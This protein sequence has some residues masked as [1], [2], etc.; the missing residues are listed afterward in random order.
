MLKTIWYCFFVQ[1]NLLTGLVNLMVDTLFASAVKALFIL[2][3]YT[4][5]LTFIVGFLDFC[6]IWLK[7]GRSKFEILES[8]MPAANWFTLNPY[9]TKV[10]ISTSKW[11]NFRRGFP[12]MRDEAWSQWVEEFELIWKQ[13]WMAKGIYELITLSKVTVIAKPKFLTIDIL[14]W[15]NGTSTFTLEWVPCLLRF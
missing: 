15:N 4:F 13:K 14:L 3:A 10:G 6:G 2:I 9:S 12:L 11:S 5:S 1:A 7:F 8:N